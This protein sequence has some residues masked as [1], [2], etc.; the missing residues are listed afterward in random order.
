MSVEKFVDQVLS[1]ARKF[2]WIKR[3][4]V[5][6]TIAWASIRLWLNESFVDVFYRKK[7]GNISYAYIESGKRLF[8][9]NNMRIGWHLHPFG[10]IERH[11]P[12]KPITIEKFL[13]MLEKELKKRGKLT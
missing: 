9:A 5:E 3:H 4:K 7:T 11:I 8:G 12:T 1:A 6:A 13:K 2:R 10:E